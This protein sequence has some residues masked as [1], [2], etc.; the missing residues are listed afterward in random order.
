M[1]EIF[2]IILFF[3]Q[4]RRRRRGKQIFFFTL[5]WCVHHKISGKRGPIRQ[6]HLGWSM[7]LGCGSKRHPRLRSRRPPSE[8]D[9]GRAAA[10]RVIRL[11]ALC[12]RFFSARAA[13]CS[14]V[15]FF[16]AAR[17]PLRLAV[18]PRGAAPPVCKLLINRPRAALRIGSLFS[19]RACRLRFMSHHTMERLSDQSEFP[20]R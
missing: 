8:T 11:C 15:V 1:L 9:F 13:G 18:L 12:L 14:D 19:F 5:A 2:M 10:P 17:G 6:R 20:V 3:F 7:F 16:G 4:M